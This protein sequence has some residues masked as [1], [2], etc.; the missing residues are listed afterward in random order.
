[1]FYMGADKISPAFFEKGESS[2]DVVEATNFTGS[3]INAGDKVYLNNNYNTSSNSWVYNDSNFS[4]FAYLYPI[5]ITY[6]NVYVH[7]YSQSADIINNYRY[8]TSYN[9]NDH[10]SL[11]TFMN[12]NLYIGDYKILGEQKVQSSIGYPV[13]KNIFLKFT[14]S[15]FHVIV[16]DFENNTV[17]NDYTLSTTATQPYLSHARGLLIGDLLYLSTGSSRPGYAGNT[18]NVVL[19]IKTGVESED[20]TGVC[21]NI[22][23][24]YVV[25]HSS[26]YKYLFSNIYSSNGALSSRLRIWEK[27][28]NG[29]YQY[30]NDVSNLC[31]D[32]QPYYGTDYTMS[33]FF[34]YNDILCVATK[35]TTDQLII[36]YNKDTKTF[37]NL[38]IDLP[39]LSVNDYSFNRN[40][41]FPCISLDMSLIVIARNCSSVNW[42]RVC[43][44][45]LA[46]SP[47]GYKA[48]P[49]DGRHLDTN[50]ITGK[51][52]GNADVGEKFDVSTVLI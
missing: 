12:D 2:G 24:K 17:I 50:T 34:T 30:L 44:Y 14:N 28:D 48:I 18:V 29:V 43:I 22:L 47:S 8:N 51:A 6:D 45:R 15:E 32:L 11:Y 40:Y 36:K 3:S 23:S 7:N 42:T 39:V 38:N 10:Y 20:T 46:Q 52:L 33:Q 13:D 1:M 37:T 26:D 31:Q 4:N 16:Y 21:S 41:S 19:N 25:N 27:D 35:D 49:Y 9:I 5:A